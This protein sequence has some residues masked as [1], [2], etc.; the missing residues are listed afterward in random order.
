MV[1]PRTEARVPGSF[2]SVLGRTQI[3]PSRG[4]SWVLL[5][6]DVIVDGRCL[7]FA[8]LFVNVLKTN[9]IYDV[10]VRKCFSCQ[11][12][13]LLPPLLFHVLDDCITQRGP[14]KFVLE[15]V[16]KVYIPA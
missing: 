6:R 2:G 14:S 13:L 5:K 8:G 4:L 3:R 1:L 15:R 7:L 16:K 11:Y 12:L 9:H 10:L